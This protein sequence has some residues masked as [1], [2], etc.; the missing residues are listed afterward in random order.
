MNKHKIEAKVNGKS[1]SFAVDSNERLIDMLRNRMGLTGTKEGCGKG[2]CG[3]CVVIVDGKTVN[4]CLMLAAQADG[5][6]IVTIE[7][8]GTPKKL[9]PLQKAFVEKGAIQRARRSGRQSVATS[10]GARGTSRSS[11]PYKRRPPR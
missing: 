1:V 2:D 7:G 6:E 9:H 11:T 3:S 8:L 10:A 4:S 5:R